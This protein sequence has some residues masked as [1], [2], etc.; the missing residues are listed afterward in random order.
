MINSDRSIV[1]LSEARRAESKGRRGIEGVGRQRIEV[2][3][4][5][6]E[7]RGRMSESRCQTSESERQEFDL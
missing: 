5:T 7:F 6:S 3:Y 4:Q 1:T 2:R